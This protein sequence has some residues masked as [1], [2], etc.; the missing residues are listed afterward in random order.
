IA[1]RAAVHAVAFAP[2]GHDLITGSIDGS[3]LIT[4]DGREPIALPPMPGGIDAVAILADGRVVVA[5]ASNRLRIMDRGRSTVVAEL[6]S[7]FRVRSL[8]PSPDGARMI[9]LST[10]A[11]QAPPA[12][13]DLERYRLLRRLEG[14]IGRVFAARFATSGHGIV[15]AGSDGTVRLWDAGNGDLRRTY[16]GDWHFL[17]DATLSPDGAIVVAGSSDGLLRFWDASSARLLWTLQ[18]HKSYVV[19]VHYEGSDIVTRS[20]AGEIA[21]WTLPPSQR[22]VEA[23][24]QTTCASAVLTEM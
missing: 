23:C 8:R 24:H 12:L 11:I 20:L 2:T 16:R 1:H 18:A 9:A 14:H 4:A 3:V 5:D 13:W 6:A 7:P 17:A 15:T 10:R 19:G 22:I 21:R